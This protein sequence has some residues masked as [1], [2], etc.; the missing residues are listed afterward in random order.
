MAGM[1]PLERHEL[2]SPLER[3]LVVISHPDDAEFGAAATIA[4][5]TASGVRVDYVVTT[6]GGKGTEDPTVTPE[7]LSTTRMA[8][9]RA[10]ADIL[11]VTKIVHLGYPDGYLIPS[12]DLR[13]DITRQI[14]RFRPDL[15]LTQNPQ[16]RLDHNPFI[17][18]PDHLATGEATLASVYPAA[19]DHLN[20]PELWTDEK[21]EPWKVR[22]VL[23]TGVEEPNLWLDVAETFD[24]GVRSILAHVSQVDPETVEERVRERARIVGEPQGIGLAQAFASIILE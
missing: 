15:V 4:Q 2:I 22:Q 12:L 10:A 21:L 23:L 18:H 11:G 16:R 13:R 24:I 1:S 14:R 6:D 19:R 8:E 9:Q 3:A 20:F 17:G 5:L 7:Q